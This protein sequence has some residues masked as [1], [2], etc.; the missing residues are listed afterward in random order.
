MAFTVEAINVKN[1]GKKA[2]KH[3]QLA[4]FRRFF[5]AVLC[6]SQ[7]TNCHIK[8]KSQDRSHMAE[9]RKNVSFHVPF[10]FCNG[11]KRED[12]GAQYLRNALDSHD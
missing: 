3:A 5:F 11:K 1:T 12:I 8:K 4:V 9:K 7:I 10:F 6:L 2:K